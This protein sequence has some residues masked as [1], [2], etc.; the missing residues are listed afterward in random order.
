MTRIIGNYSPGDP[1]RK[2]AEV[3]KANSDLPDGCCR[4]LWVGSAGTANITTKEGDELT[5]FPLL[6]GLNPIMVVRVSTG[7]TADNIW[8]LY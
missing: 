4:G 2:V 5:D 3:T 1:A 7:G 8:A 6:A